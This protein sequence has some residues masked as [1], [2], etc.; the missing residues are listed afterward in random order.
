M[1][2][3]KTNDQTATEWNTEEIHFSDETRHQRSLPPLAKLRT[4]KIPK[5]EQGQCGEPSSYQRSQS[6]KNQIW[7]PVASLRRFPSLLES[8]RVETG[9][10]L[11]VE[12]RLLGFG[13]GSEKF[14]LDRSVLF[15]RWHSFSGSSSPGLFVL[16]QV[17]GRAPLVLSIVPAFLHSGRSLKLRILLGGVSCVSRRLCFRIQAHESSDGEGLGGSLSTDLVESP[18]WSEMD[19]LFKVWTHQ[20]CFIDVCIR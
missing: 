11:L 20:F 4:A 5:E 6:K 18:F 17:V 13:S 2:K 15:R 7:S 1:T 14:S 8:W 10:W 16:L 19:L 12:G 3:R 9:R